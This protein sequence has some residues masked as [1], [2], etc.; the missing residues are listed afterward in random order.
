MGGFLGWWFNFLFLDL[1]A[2]REVCSVGENSE[3]CTFLIC[4]FLFV[5]YTSMKKC[6]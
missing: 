5:C 4:A 6:A 1:G 3:I 2:V